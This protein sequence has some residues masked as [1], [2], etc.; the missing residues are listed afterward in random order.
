MRLK[1][2]DLN[3]EEVLSCFVDADWAGDKNDRKS[4]S[5]FVF[6]F[7]GSPIGWTSRKQTT[8]ALSSSE[9]EFI[10]FSEASRELLWVKSVIADFG[11]H[12]NGPVPVYEDNQSCISML[13]NKKANQRT[14]HIDTKFKF[15]QQLI[16]KEIIRCLYCPTD[17]M[18][19]DILTKPLDAGQHSKLA[20]RLGLVL[21]IQR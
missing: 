8:V 13:H 15:G 6:Y 14:K 2:G 18:I 10:A 16:E 20:N 11:E 9:A 3:S 7:Y 21:D 1:L 4:N 19:A 17:L 12:I 5:G